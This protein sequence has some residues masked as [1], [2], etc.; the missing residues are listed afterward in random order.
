MQGAIYVETTKSNLKTCILLFHN[1]DGTILFIFKNFCA[2]NVAIIQGQHELKGST[3]LRNREVGLIVPA[4]FIA[5]MKE[6]HVARILER[7][8]LIVEL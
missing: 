8:P 3:N 5:L 4:N 7:E 1:E 6:L 2:S